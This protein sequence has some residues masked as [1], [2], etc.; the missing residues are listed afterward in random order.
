MKATIKTAGTGTTL[1][2]GTKVDEQ[3]Y[4]AGFVF[5]AVSSCA[6]GLL[7]VASLI[8]GMIV[9]GGPLGLVGNLFRAIIG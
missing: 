9:S 2:T 5:F 7:S 6:I 8:S 1:N 4:K 3:V